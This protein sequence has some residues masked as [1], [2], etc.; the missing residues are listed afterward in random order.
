MEVPEVQHPVNAGNL[1]QWQRQVQEDTVPAEV[2]LVLCHEVF[3]L[4]SSQ[5]FQFILLFSPPRLHLNAVE[6]ERVEEGGQEARRDQEDAEDV[7]KLAGEDGGRHVGQVDDQA[8][9][10]HGGAQTCRDPRQT[11]TEKV[12]EEGQPLESL[13]AIQVSSDFTDLRRDCASEPM[14]VQVAVRSALDGRTLRREKLI[15]VA[16]LGIVLP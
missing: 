2:A 6:A 3:V 15:D 10:E 7:E 11:P 4:H 5:L 16:L 8:D 1:A 12:L 9:S 14:Q 13:L